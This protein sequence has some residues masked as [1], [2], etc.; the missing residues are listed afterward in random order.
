MNG[1][2]DTAS[3]VRTTG[4]PEPAESADPVRSALG[5]RQ[6]PRMR[7]AGTPGIR[8]QPS[9]PR[10]GTHPIAQSDHHE[11]ETQMIQPYRIP[12]R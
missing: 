11:E 5:T 10:H 3:P 7:P 4:R 8:R 12:R 2:L 9:P 1:H 6:R